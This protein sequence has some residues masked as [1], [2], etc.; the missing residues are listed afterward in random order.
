M[1]SEYLG[2]LLRA[3][4]QTDPLRE[5]DMFRNFIQ[6]F[7]PTVINERLDRYGVEALTT[8]EARQAA[9]LFRQQFAEYEAR[10]QQPEGSGESTA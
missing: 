2:Q 3:F 7:D 6:L 8:P 10:Q 9:Q 5:G 1:K 4:L